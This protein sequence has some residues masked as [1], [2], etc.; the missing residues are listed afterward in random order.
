M[1]RGAALR[2]RK[3]WRIENDHVEFFAAARQALQNGTHIVG[4]EFMSFGGKHVE[5]ERPPAALARLLGK[6]D[7]HRLRASG[8]SR[9][10]ER[11]GVSKSIQDPLRFQLSDEFAVF[12]LIDEEPDRIA[13]AEIDSE[14]ETMLRC[15]RLQTFGCLAKQKRGRLTLFIF[16]RQKSRENPIDRK[17]NRF[18]P[19]IEFLNETIPRSRRP[20]RNQN[21]ATD[22]LR[23]AVVDR[24][25]TMR[26]GPFSFKRVQ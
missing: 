4:N 10:R 1:K 25:K 20:E 16:L 11:A 21:V 5:L 22:T 24:A 14:F 6:L 12:A 13:N 3:R 9:H 15:D 26:V 23:P 18:A 17:L 7:I 2:P 8:P 19:G